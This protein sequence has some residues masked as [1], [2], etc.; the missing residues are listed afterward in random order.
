MW[1]KVPE[2]RIDK[3]TKSSDKMKTA[4]LRTALHSVHAAEEGARGSTTPKKMRGPSAF[5]IYHNEQK[6]VLQV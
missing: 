3:T 1:R 2:R 5:V 4:A 6:A